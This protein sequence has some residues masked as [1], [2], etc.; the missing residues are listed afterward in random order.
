MR[1]E[2]WEGEIMWWKWYSQWPLLF[3][4]QHVPSSFLPI[5]QCSSSAF[6][7]SS[8]L[9]LFLFPIHRME[10]EEGAMEANWE[11]G[12]REQSDA[13]GNSLIW[14]HQWTRPGRAACLYHEVNLADVFEPGSNPAHWIH[15][16]I[17]PCYISYG[18]LQE[19]TLSIDVMWYVNKILAVLMALWQ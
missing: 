19:E 16:C 14:P 12:V 1:W 5:A 7:S 9:S 3:Y 8:T 10:R 6:S 17:H 18:F 4:T 2:E 15:H 11:T 13:W